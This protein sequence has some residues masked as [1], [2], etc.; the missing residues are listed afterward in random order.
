MFA[1]AFRLAVTVEA[2]DLARDLLGLVVLIVGLDDDDGRAAAP[3]GPE[4]LVLARGVVPDDRVR[5]VEDPLGAA[6]VL[7]ELH[8]HGVGVVTLEVEDVADVRTA[9]GEDRL[10]VVADDGEVLTEP[11]EVPQQHVLRTVRVLVFVHQDVREAVLPALQGAIADLEQAAREQ[12][13]VVEVDGVVLPEQRV[14]PGPDGRGDALELLVP[15][16]GE[17]GRAMQLVLG[18][19]DDR[20]HRARGEDALG[21][22]AL[23]HRLADQRALVRLVVDR[24]RPVDADERPLPPQ[25]ASTE[26]VERA[27]GEIPQRGLAEQAAQPLA[28]LASRLVGKGDGQDGARGN[29][30]VPDQV[31]DAVRQHARL[32]RS[33]AGQDQQRPVAMRHRRALLGIE[34]VE[35]LVGH[36]PKRMGLPRIT[37]VDRPWKSRR[38]RGQRSRPTARTCG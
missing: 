11:R 14:V 3:L 5:G 37:V 20:G 22:A 29:A 25:Q 10:V 19:R 33:G 17:V 24:E 2:L 32:A 36:R 13:E 6:V 30:E 38:L 21:V 27:D 28:H 16:G 35:D 12:E 8:H 4:P 1:R 18:A 34:R 7:L 9:P 23:G 31:R 15:G 26:A